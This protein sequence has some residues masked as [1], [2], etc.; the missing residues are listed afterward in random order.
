MERGAI[1]AVIIAVLAA[2]GLVYY[3]GTMGH[4]PKGGTTTY[5]G[6]FSTV[7]VTSLTPAAVQFYAINVQYIYQG[8]Q[9]KGGINCSYNSYTYVDTGQNQVLNGSQSF[10][11]SYPISSTACPM[12]ITSV[13]V[14]TSGFAFLGTVPTLP[15]TIPKNSQAQ[16]QF[17]LRTPSVNFYGPLTIT[18]FYS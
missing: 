4:A 18:I 6:G 10:Y 12:T 7:P 13:A 1:I 2:I 16:L 11:L 9:Y 15:L 8:P 14:N 3:L 17:N 5:S